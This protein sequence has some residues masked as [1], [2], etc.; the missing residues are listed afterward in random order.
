[1]TGVS[2]VTNL[3][4]IIA[5]CIF[6]STLQSFYYFLSAFSSLFWFMFWCCTVQ[7]PSLFFFKKTA[8]FSTKALSGALYAQQQA[9]GKVCNKNLASKKTEFCLKSRWR[10]KLN[11]KQS[12][13]TLQGKNMSGLCL[14]LDVLTPNSLK[15]SCFKSLLMCHMWQLMSQGAALA[16]YQ[17]EW[18]KST[19]GLGLGGWMGQT[20]ENRAQIPCVDK[21]QHGLVFYSSYVT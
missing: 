17:T 18:G 2:H 15:I 12:D 4:R 1:M 3:Q 16:W 13:S 11:W 21:S 8:I 14:Q 19:P 20:W 5:N 10:V 7:L 9:A 6:P